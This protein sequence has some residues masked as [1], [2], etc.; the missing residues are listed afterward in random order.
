MWKEWRKTKAA[1]V[2]GSRKKSCG[3]NREEEG[4]EILG[5][6]AR[7]RNGREGRK[8]RRGE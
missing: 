2:K 7:R 6:G 1:K 3:E 8:G 4:R 5:W